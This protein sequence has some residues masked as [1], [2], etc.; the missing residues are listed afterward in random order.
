MIIQLLLSAL[1]NVL[2]ILLILNIPQ[3]PDTVTGYLND[4][5]DYLVSGAS[6]LA[7]YTP[8]GYLLTLFGVLVAVDVGLNIYRFVMWIIKKIP[9]LGIS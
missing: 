8:L 2:N 4:F 1:Y 6:I 5:F 3:L 9:M 7:N